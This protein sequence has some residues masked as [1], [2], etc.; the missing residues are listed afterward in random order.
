MDPNDLINVNAVEMKLDQI[1][2]GEMNRGNNNS[3][4]NGVLKRT[5]KNESRRPSSKA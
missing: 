3:K 4:G 2:V 1:A 5:I